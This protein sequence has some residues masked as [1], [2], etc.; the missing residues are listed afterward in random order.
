MQGGVS[1]RK[2]PKEEGGINSGEGGRNE[3]GTGRPCGETETG[4][5]TTAVRKTTKAEQAH[6]GRGQEHREQVISDN[7]GG[8]HRARGDG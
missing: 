1:G 4:M 6:R 8:E 2:G 3:D 7:N 5:R